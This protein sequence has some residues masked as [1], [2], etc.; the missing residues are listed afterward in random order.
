MRVAA[1]KSSSSAGGEIITYPS[2]HV[3]QLSILN[4]AWLQFSSVVDFVCPVEEDDRYNSV[5]ISEKAILA[6]VVQFQ[7]TV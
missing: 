5:N 3:V 4:E 6:S 1:L 7:L 2:A